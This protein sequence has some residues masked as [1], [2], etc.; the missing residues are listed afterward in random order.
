MKENVMAKKT[1]LEMEYRSLTEPE[2]CEAIRYLEPNSTSGTEENSP[3]TRGNLDVTINV[4]LRGVEEITEQTV[5]N[6]IGDK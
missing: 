5:I 2:I 3:A 1:R 6:P 4:V